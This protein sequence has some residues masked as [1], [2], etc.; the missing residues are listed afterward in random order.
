MRTSGANY[1]AVMVTQYQQTS[2]S[3]TI[4]PETTNSP[5]YSGQYPLTP[6]DAA[7]VSAIKSLQAQG[8]VVSMKPQVDL[9]DGVF[10]GS[11]MPTNPAAWFSSYQ[12][13][14]LHYAR[15]AAQNNVGMLVIGTEFKSL[16]NMTYK[17][18]WETIIT[19]LRTQYPG[20]TLT[21]AANATGSG[22][23]FTSVSFWADLD[24]IGVDGYFP[25]TNQNDP[26]L[27]ALVAAWT[28]NRSGFNIVNALKNLQS[29]YNKPLIFTEIG[30]VSVAGTN[31]TPYA[32]I[33]GSYDAI[34]QQNCYEAFFEVF[35]QQTAWMKGVFWWEY[36]PTAPAA[37]DIG[38]TP[39]N[40][41]A[42]TVTLPKWFSNTTSGFTIAPAQST[43][44][45]G[46]GLTTSNNVSVSAQGGFSGSVVFTVSGLPAGVTGSF[47]TGAATGTQDLILTASSAAAITG[48]VTV[49][50]TGT[51]GA[52][53]ATTTFALSIVAPVAQ[54][55]TLANP[56]AQTIGATVSL[57]AT[58]NSFLAITYATTTPTIC[59][60]TSS[61]GTVTTLLAG[62]CTVT[63]SQASGATF[64]AG[65][66]S[67]TFAVSGL[68]AATV[69]VNALVLV[70]QVNYRANVGGY[71]LSAGNPAGGSL[72]VNSQGTA[73]VANNINVEAVNVMT[74]TLTTLGAWG[75]AAAVA[76]DPSNNAYVGNSY[77]PVNSIVK[78]PFVGGT[79]NAGYAAFTTPTLTTPI[80]VAGGTTE[81][82]LPANLGS[83]NV[84][85][86]TFDANGNL[87]FATSGSGNTSGNSIYECNVAC[88][89]G[90][91]APIIVYTEATVSPAPSSTSGQLLVG[92]IAVDSAG[93]LF[94]TDS[95]IFTNL[96]T[97]A[98][99]SFSSNVKEL[100]VSSGTGF[101]GV[102]TGFSAT[103]VT[104]YT[105]NTPSPAAYG[106]Q[107]NGVVVQHN[108]SGDVIYFADA[109]DGVFGFPDSPGGIPVVAGKPTAL[110]TA[111]LQGGKNLGIDA[112]GNLYPIGYSSA[113]GSG[114]DTLAQITLNAIQ[115]PPSPTG[116]AV[117]P[118]TIT[119]PITTILN[120]SSCGGTPAPSITFA[121]S[122]SSTAMATATASAS[123][124]STFT[125]SAAFGTVVSFTPAAAGPDSVTISATDSL[126]N[127]GTATISG[128]G[129]GFSITP[130]STSATI[131]QGSTATDN[132]IV[133]NFGGFTGS[134]TLAATGLPTGVTASF[135]TNP[136]SNASVLTLTATAGATLGN[137]TVTI[138]GISGATNAVATLNLTVA[139][140]PAYTIAPAAA[141]LSVTQ[142]AT[143]TDTINITGGPGF[144]SAVAFSVSGL[145]S[146]VTAS[147]S[148]N[149]TT[150]ATS[151]LTLTATGTAA[152]GG[153]LN[154]TITGTAG[155]VSQTATVALTI[156][157]AP[158]FTLAATPAGVTVGQGSTNTST[159]TVTNVGG[160]TGSVTLGVA[161]L[162]AGVTASVSTNPT[163]SSSVITFTAAATAS[164][165]SSTVVVTGT[166]GT[167]TASTSIALT[168]AGPPSFTIAA[169]SSTL[170]LQQG[171]SKTDTITVAGSNGFNGSVT[172]AATGLPVGVTVAFAT[173][174]TTGTSVATFSAAATAPAG[175]GTVTITG[176]SGTLSST[177]TVAITVTPAPSFTLTPSPASLIL[178]QG[179]TAMDT[180]TVV[181]AN[182]F[183]GPVV[184][185]AS[186]LPSG[187][188][189]TF[190]TNTAGTSAVLSLTA[191]ATA[192]TGGPVNIMVTGTSGSTTGSIPIALTVNVPP[193]F[194]LTANPAAL[195][196]AQTTTGSTTITVTP[197]GGFTGTPKL[198]ASGLPTGVTASFAPGSTAGTQI[199]SL[200]VSTAADALKV[201]TTS[202]TITGTS[203]TITSST[204]VAITVIPPP[205]FTFTG[206]PIII[207]HGTTVQNSA[208][209]SILAINGFSGT[210]ALTCAITPVAAANAPTCSL[211][212]STVTLAGVVAQTTTLTITSTPGALVD[213]RRIPMLWA[214]G[215]GG[216]L[217][218]VFFL[219]LPK[220]H[221]RWQSLLLVLLGLGLLSGIG[222]ATTHQTTTAAD[223]TPTGTYAV[224][225]TGTAGSIVSSGNISLTIQ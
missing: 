144:S 191:S 68:P 139:A 94:F 105:L 197:L 115:I 151:I 156:N 168:T 7:V 52:Q 174:P 177:T 72:G 31:K 183:S 148:P 166:S 178:I 124:A 18:N 173:N 92:S 100:A 83:I 133:T 80:C 130:A 222:C 112:S 91:G 9:L 110:F 111:G 4:A 179:T 65:T 146:G 93:N 176:I 8:L 101:G 196:I 221:L 136:T 36:S 204:V 40:K 47:T 70:S 15:L 56:G 145:P 154:V 180:L 62:S 202:I 21:Y 158:T 64:S 116:M 165:G 210:V 153:P 126:N 224:T 43:V 181:A 170:S 119:S 214:S 113:T 220:R 186:S 198:V 63:A 75:N 90:T 23:E 38:Y 169:A 13:F 107:V 217:A 37:N 223:G 208:P 85:T 164:L 76:V 188:T 33:Q 88:L 211:S 185:T 51:S 98:Y 213:D 157:A 135:G 1:A 216:V 35:S 66:T 89:S 187:V 41:P 123:C 194:T 59:S 167:A 3:T 12:T 218:F 25:L 24:V 11:F 162:P 74:G 28:S 84:S 86:M 147:F 132:I 219:G 114:G 131:F 212:P 142:G 55:I 45:L 118:S 42:G 22:D 77:G 129:V 16:T 95:S 175:T 104:L 61:A 108:S 121:S 5:G 205:G 39:Q 81:C 201:P 82:L 192:T 163:T 209:I 103:P 53:T 32:N 50:V 140:V 27:S 141:A 48:P 19:Q 184:F 117:S 127:A 206:G 10:R 102:T 20:L 203:G 49:T 87:F 17:S 193:S 96:S 79:V 109:F 182:G 54:T 73:I 207:K 69:P 160:F 152:V 120:D 138:T 172:L 128:T 200:I 14:I 137:A 143:G 67:Q 122:P 58:S 190:A 99:Y 46:Q 34:E 78:I 149:P 57:A 29:T 195:S 60:V 155:S 125:G 161:G 2:T 97:Y 71:A 6:T 225:I 106:N 199:L 26:S 30:Y 215:G 171:S 44:A 150:F 189:A 159:V 134:V